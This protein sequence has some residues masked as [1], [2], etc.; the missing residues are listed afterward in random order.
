VKEASVQ[1]YGVWTVRGMLFDKW[2]DARASDIEL[3]CPTEVSIA[4]TGKGDAG[5]AI[6][7][8]Q[9]IY[10]A[11]ISLIL[12]RAGEGKGGEAMSDCHSKSR[13]SNFFIIWSQTWHA[14]SGV[15]RTVPCHS[16]TNV[17]DK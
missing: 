9:V 5:L 10:T 16:P 12:A 13:R 8:G 14:A 1:K 3:L 11:T 17:T 2:G 15:S 7:P 4:Q 6:L